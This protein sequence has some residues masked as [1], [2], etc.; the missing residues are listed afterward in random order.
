MIVLITMIQSSLITGQ[1]N[2]EMIDSVMENSRGS[3]SGSGANAG[4][5]KQK[6]K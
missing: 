3:G 1:A 5:K 6:K 4:K 2:D